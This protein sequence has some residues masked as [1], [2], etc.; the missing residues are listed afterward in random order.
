MSDKVVLSPLSPWLLL[1]HNQSKYKRSVSVYKAPTP[2]VSFHRTIMTQ[3]TLLPIRN[4]THQADW[5]QFSL[6]GHVADLD[7]VMTR[8]PELADLLK[9]LQPSEDIDIVVKTNGVKTVELRSL[10]G[11]TRQLSLF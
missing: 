10:W 5:Q 6:N 2:D 9:S 3:T 4:N 1:H 7:E 11:E 8:H